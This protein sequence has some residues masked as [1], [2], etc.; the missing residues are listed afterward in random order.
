MVFPV[1]RLESSV[2]SLI[3]FRTFI[4]SGTKYHKEILNCEIDEYICEKV[5]DVAAFY[6]LF[7]LMERHLLRFM[8]RVD[9]RMK[10]YVV[11][12]F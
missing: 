10:M 9:F 11:C 1:L 3:I 5:A 12:A 7:R 4:N 8:T 6:F 2:A